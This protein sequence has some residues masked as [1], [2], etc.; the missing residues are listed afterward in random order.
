MNATRY[1]WVAVLAPMA[2]TTAMAG[3]RQENFDKDPGWDGHNNRSAKPETIRQD[4]GWSAGTTN[5]GGAPGEIG[6]RITVTLDGH[7]VSLELAPEHQG[8]GGQFDR[9]ALVTPWIDGNGQQV[10]FDDLRYTWRQE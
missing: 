2:W 1:L 6:G 7:A 5:S 10:Y 4:F 3:Q 9:F 8:A